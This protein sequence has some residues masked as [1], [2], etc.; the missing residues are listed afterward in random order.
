MAGAHVWDVHPKS[1]RVRG[2]WALLL[3]HLPPRANCFFPTTRGA[4][5]V[6]TPQCERAV[7]DV[8]YS[9]TLVNFAFSLFVFY[10]ENEARVLPL[11][12][13]REG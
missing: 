2:P 3:L 5:A 7:L 1:T 8:T 11:L 10:F 9:G 13:D 6:H 4:R 12:R